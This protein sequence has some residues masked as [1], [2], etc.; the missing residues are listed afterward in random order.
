ME[1]L[2]KIF[3]FIHNNQTISNLTIEGSFKRVRIQTFSSVA[4]TILN[5]FKESVEYN[6]A[7]FLPKI[8]CKPVT[9]AAF[10]IARYKI[11]IDFFHELNKLLYDHIKTLPPKLWN[12]FRLVAGDGTTISLPATPDIKNHFKIYETSK[13]NTHTVLAN[14]CIFYDVLSNFVLDVNLDL[15][16][17]GELPMVNELIDRAEFTNTIVL[18]DRGFGYFGT[19]KRLL[20]KKLDFCI[21]LKARGSTFAKEALSNPSNDFITEWIPSEGS[22]LSSKKHDLDVNPILVRITKITLNTGEIEVLVSSLLDLKQ[23]KEADMKELYSRRWGV[24]EGIK[25]MKPKMK[26]EQFG[27]RKQEG[28]YQEFY[29]H[30]FMMNL[31]TLIGN[32]TQEEIDRVTIKRKNAYKYNWQN[33]FRFVRNQFISIFYLG[34]IQ[35]SVEKLNEQIQASLTIIKPDRSFERHKDKRKHRYAQCYK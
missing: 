1:L 21:R 10:S 18:L 14:C 17:N 7:T 3:D 34:D 6:L 9:G 31:V 13:G 8:Q 26:L 23:I 4:L 28:V 33:A 15:M 30:I 24:E 20:N 29:A 25:K 19:C 5:L 27:C 11:K 2:K 35:R 22:R 32:E 12:G 16:S